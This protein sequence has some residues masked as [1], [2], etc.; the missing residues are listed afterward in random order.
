VVVWTD[1]RFVR[2]ARYVA[3]RLR[4]LG[5]RATAREVPVEEWLATAYGPKEANT[6]QVGL[7]AW[8]IDYPAPSTFFEQLRCGSADPARFCDPTIDRQMDDALALQTTDPVA[9]D[10]RWA[11]IDRALTDQAA[12][13]GYATP[14]KVNFL[15]SRVGNFQFH[16]VWWMLLDQLWVR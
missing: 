6:I 7:S 10:E 16:P 11:K 14:R 5:Y 12:W 15:G 9:A 2:E 8:V 1:H 13:I 4:Q 3:G